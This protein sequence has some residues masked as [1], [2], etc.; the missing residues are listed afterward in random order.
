MRVARRRGSPLQG[1]FLGLIRAYQLL[2]GP[3]LGPACR[4][5]PSCSLYAIEAIERYGALR[6]VWIAARRLSRC[7][8]FG[9]FG[10]DP[11]P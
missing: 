3:Q 10:M 7:R 1:L 6:G 11:L 9:G 4:F 5:E 8:P 2:L